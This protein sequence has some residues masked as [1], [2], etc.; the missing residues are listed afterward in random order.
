[1]MM[2]EV[3]SFEDQ[4]MSKYSH[5]TTMNDVKRYMFNPN[6]GTHTLLQ[7]GEDPDQPTESVPYHFNYNVRCSY[8]H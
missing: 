8:L 1:M 4:G 5:N 6:D 7:P 3:K 2:I